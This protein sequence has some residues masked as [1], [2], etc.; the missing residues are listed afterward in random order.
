MTT[1][2]QEIAP[3]CFAFQC[4]D[5]GTGWFVTKCPDKVER[6]CQERH[7]TV[8]AVGRPPASVRL[9]SWWTPD[10]RSVYRIK[11]DRDRDLSIADRD[12]RFTVANP[13]GYEFEDLQRV[14][15]D[16]ETGEEVVAA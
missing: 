14:V 15:A 7:A 4:F 6:F 16:Y 11:R 13:V 1:G 3:G 5:A 12:A 9:P 8:N 2:F 10:L